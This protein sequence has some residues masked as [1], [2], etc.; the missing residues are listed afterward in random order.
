ML[1]DRE[2]HTPQTQNNLLWAAV[3]SLHCTFLQDDIF[4]YHI[5]VWSVLIGMCIP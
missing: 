2:K 3:Q 1:T 4:T 5:Q